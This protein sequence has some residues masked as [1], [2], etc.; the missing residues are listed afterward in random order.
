[1][2][3]RIMER[4]GTSTVYAVNAQ[5]QLQGLVRI[6]DAIALE[7]AGAKTIPEDK[8]ITDLFITRPDTPVGDLLGRAMEAK[9]PISICDDEGRLRGILDRATVLGEVVESEQAEATLSLEEM[10]STTSD[11]N[12]AFAREDIDAEI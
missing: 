9:Y 7:K 12:A 8:L 10:K 1:M 4:N 5:R 11:L 2:A 3:V 6:D